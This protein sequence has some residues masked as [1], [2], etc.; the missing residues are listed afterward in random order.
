[1]I[2]LNSASSPAIVY[3]HNEREPR[4]SEI[5]FKTFE[6]TLYIH[7]QNVLHPKSESAFVYTQP[8]LYYIS[9]IQMYDLSLNQ[10][11]DMSLNQMYDIS[12]A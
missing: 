5:Y 1:M 4:E 8:K 12:P 3:T 10:M 6:K 9:L 11:Y 2:F 7:N